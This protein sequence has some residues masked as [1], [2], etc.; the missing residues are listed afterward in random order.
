[1]SN[2]ISDQ[3]PDQTRITYSFIYI[4]IITYILIK[5]HALNDNS[6]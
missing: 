2:T 3:G 5:M 4:H 6:Y 1:M